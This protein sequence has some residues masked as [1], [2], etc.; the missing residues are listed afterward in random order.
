MHKETVTKHQYAHNE[1]CVKR[2]WLFSI[3]RVQ[4]VA[5]QSD[6]VDLG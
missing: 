4:H 1:L 2:R 3:G 5:I 6:Q